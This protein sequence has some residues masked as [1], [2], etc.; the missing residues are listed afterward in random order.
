MSLKKRTDLALEAHELC[1]EAGP[2]DLSALPGVRSC[3]RT[4][5]HCGI[6]EVEVL[7]QQ[8]EQRLQK[9]PGR[10]ITLELPEG[11]VR[12]EEIFQDCVCALAQELRSLLPRREGP[13]LVAGLGNRSMTADAIGP[14][15]LEHLL[16]T[17]HLM[18]ELPSSEFRS[19]CA[20]SPGVLGITGVE[21]AEFLQ[22]LLLPLQPAALVVIDA[23]AARK[24]QRVCSTV[25]LGSSGIIPGSGVGNHRQPLNEDTLHLPVL[26]VG[27]PTVVDAATLIADSLESAGFTEKELPFP[28]NC[29]VTP[30]DI[31]AKV[32]CL[33]KLLGYG[34][35]LALQPNLEFSQ[36]AALLS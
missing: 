7:D 9:P 5:G 10:Y 27:V 25:Q 13:V 8:G 11:H 14:L 33:A 1:R 17:R 34:I 21:T 18:E 22:G 16:V 2:G 32:R 35:S 19:V 36:L 20:A 12:Q 6:T 31:D 3:Q 30:R 24:M 26:A 23:L 15:T 29:F 4:R 28:E